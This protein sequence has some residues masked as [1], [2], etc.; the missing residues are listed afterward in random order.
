MQLIS[1]RFL[2]PLFPTSVSGYTGAGPA[3]WG[4][5]CPRGPWDQQEGAPGPPASCVGRRDVWGCHLCWKC[6]GPVLGRRQAILLTAQFIICRTVI[7]PPSSE[8]FQS[9]RRG[10]WGFWELTTHRWGGFKPKG[11][12]KLR[13]QLFRAQG[14]S[15]RVLISGWLLPPVRPHGRDGEVGVS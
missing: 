6:R 14:Q 4:A 1:R 9:R 12:F 11:G 7:S 8:K 13:C 2:A 15:A 3:C 5:Q 10:G